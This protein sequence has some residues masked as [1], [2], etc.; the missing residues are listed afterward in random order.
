MVL[1]EVGVDVIT[2]TIRIVQL[3]R[4]GH[5]GCGG[6]DGCWLVSMGPLAVLARDCVPGLDSVADPD[7]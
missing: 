1:P 3:L 6:V 7:E 5:P 2:S 4:L